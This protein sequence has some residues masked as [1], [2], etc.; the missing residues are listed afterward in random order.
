MLGGNYG[1]KTINYI[2]FY[3]SISKSERFNN[4]YEIKPV[5]I[6]ILKKV[7]LC[8]YDFV[9]VSVFIKKKKK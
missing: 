7:G 9:L 4:A 2:Y 8:Y 3:I 5:L 1:L 6:E